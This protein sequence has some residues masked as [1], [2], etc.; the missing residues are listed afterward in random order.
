MKSPG[1]Y[2]CNT[3]VVILVWKRKVM[4]PEVSEVRDVL[5]V[6]ERTIYRLDY[7]CSE[8]H[9]HTQATDGD[10]QKQEV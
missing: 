2:N 4:T 5:A 1:L 3:C 10:G 7:R 9:G 6:A 8:H